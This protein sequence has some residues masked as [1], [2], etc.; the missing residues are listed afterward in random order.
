M[1]GQ[2][3][4][5]PDTGTPSGSRANL[6]TSRGETEREPERER[7]IRLLGMLLPCCS[8]YMEE[9]IYASQTHLALT[10]LLN[11]KARRYIWC[12]T[13][14]LSACPYVPYFREKLLSKYIG[15]QPRLCQ[16]PDH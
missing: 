4:T 7:E 6:Y 14:V 13:T 8:S 12:L 1:G 11:A 9:F 16:N 3:E 5:G 2:R 10:A 15:F